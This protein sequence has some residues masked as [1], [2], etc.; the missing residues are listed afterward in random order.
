MKSERVEQRKRS[1]SRQ[2]PLSFPLKPQERICK[3]LIAH[4]LNLPL[5]SSNQ[6]VRQGGERKFRLFQH[7]EEYSHL[8]TV[9]EVNENQRHQQILSLYTDP[10]G[11]SS[12]Q[13]NKLIE[14]YIKSKQQRYDQLIE[15]NLDTL[16]NLEGNS[17]KISKDKDQQQT[18]RQTD[19][20]NQS[21]YSRSFRTHTVEVKSK[22]TP[23][24]QE[25]NQVFFQK[26][27]E[28][29]RNHIRQI[30]K[31]L[32]IERN[33]DLSLKDSDYADG[34]TIILRKSKPSVPNQIWDNLDLFKKEEAKPQLKIRNRRLRIIVFVVIAVLGLSKKYKKIFQERQIAREHFQMQQGPHLKYINFF[35]IK[36][37]KFQFRKFVDSLL[38]K[39][40]M[41]QKDQKYIKECI[42]IQREKDIIRKD[43]QKQK[44]CFFIKL[45]LQDLELI[46]RKNIVPGF[47]HHFLNLCLFSGKTTQ[48][49]QFVANR[50]KFYSKTVHSLTSEQKLLI[51][52]EFLIFTIIIPNLL[53][54]ASELDQTNKE[55]F[56][57]T[58]FHFIGIIGVLMVLFTKHFERKFEKIDGS[59]VKPIQRV[60]H[61][62]KNEQGLPCVATFS[63]SDT[64]DQDEKKIIQ[65]GF[66]YAGILELFEQ[67]PYWGEKISN[68]FNK[69]A[70]NI[71]ELIDITNVS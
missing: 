2:S 47:I 7:D 46:T 11:I 41:I 32:N 39:I 42:N 48:T 58:L 59:N 3:T 55:S 34:Q 13:D 56:L 36:Q 38:Q 26:N 62:K 8:K 12:P 21:F 61:L 53:D 17:Q 4:H 23:E 18:S 19:I 57:I 20:N 27:F 30:Q 70:K 68:Q 35:G 14:N 9:C 49:S 44:L 16:R 60:I 40:I 43:A 15:S 28:R 66:E 29:K 1:S 25:N 22:I 45:I 10:D 52:L 69:I 31:T 71:G 65:G 64:I 5:I 67:K 33:L 24:K 63:I 50:T 51:A 54:I 6:V 37:H